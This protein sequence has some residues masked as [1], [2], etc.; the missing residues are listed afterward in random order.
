[1]LQKDLSLLSVDPR[2]ACYWQKHIEDENYMRSS[3]EKYM[4]EIAIL[5][6]DKSKMIDC[7]EVIPIPKSPVRKPH[8]PAGSSLDQ[9]ERSVRTQV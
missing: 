1:L 2:T 4:S 8:L 7:S 6:Q 3:F 9:I 5:G